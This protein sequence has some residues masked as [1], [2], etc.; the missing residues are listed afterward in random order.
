MW[1]FT[2]ARSRPA[3]LD[4]APVLRINF[5]HCGKVV[6]VGEKNVHFYNVLNGCA[7]RLEH[8]S[9]V[10]DDFVLEAGLARCSLSHLQ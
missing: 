1:K 10:L 4:I 6:H 9:Q 7:G 2:M 3:R 5:V 8:N